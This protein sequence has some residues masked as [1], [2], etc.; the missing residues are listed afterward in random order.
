MA[1]VFVLW[2]QDHLGPLKLSDLNLKRILSEELTPPS[3]GREGL[4]EIL[5]MT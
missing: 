1:R 4:N 3:Q 2:R 5:M